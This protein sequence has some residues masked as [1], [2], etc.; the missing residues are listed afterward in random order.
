MMIKVYRHEKR[1]EH[2]KYLKE[3]T[4]KPENNDLNLE[5]FEHSIFNG[6]EREAII[7]LFHYLNINSHSHIFQR[8]K[9]IFD[10]R[11]EI[12]H[13]NEQVFSYDRYEDVRSSVE[14]NLRELSCK[15]YKHTKESLFTGISDYT[16][17]RLLDDEN[18][19]TVFEEINQRHYITYYDYEMLANRLTSQKP[20][21][22][23]YTLKYATEQLGIE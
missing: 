3:I 10:S 19:I 17:K 11:N 15:A 20:K 21:T 1:F 22:N 8:N 16:K 4:K 7:F 2:L 13:F 23:Y 5:T 9:D 12:A 6:I 14:N 18:Y